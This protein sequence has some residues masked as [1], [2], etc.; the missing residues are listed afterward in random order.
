MTTVP[1][2][3]GPWH[4]LGVHDWTCP[5]AVADGVPGA[6]VRRWEL[7]QMKGTPEMSTHTAHAAPAEVAD[8]DAPI[9]FT[10]TPAVEAYL[11]AAELD[12]PEAEAEAGL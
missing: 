4:G 11:D 7:A 2:L 10:L 5:A 3:P 6:T 9:P 12:G 1:C 8:P